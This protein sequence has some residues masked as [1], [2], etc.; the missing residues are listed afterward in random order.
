MR[1]HPTERKALGELL[2]QLR[3]R[4]GRSGKELAAILN[5]SQS[6][7]SRFES[8]AMFPTRDQLSE[9]LAAVGAAPTDAA[10][11]YILHTV[12]D[13]TPS[14][15]DP[16]ELAEIGARF[17][18]CRNRAR[19]TQDQAA[20]LAK[21]RRYTVA[22]FEI[23]YA[24]TTLTKFKA[25]CA[26]VG[27]DANYVLGLSAEI[28]IPDDDVLDAVHHNAV[29]ETVGSVQRHLQAILTNQTSATSEEK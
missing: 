11:A 24:G 23:G 2:R 3:H 6:K 9:F 19:L 7:I 21:I 16:V 27:A 26:A 22:Q 5:W 14:P 10:D 28:G 13:G 15:I 1:D 12:I 29:V 25:L 4:C 8:G 20:E 18:E 17:A